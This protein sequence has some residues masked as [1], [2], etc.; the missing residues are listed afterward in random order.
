MLEKLLRRADA[1]ATA[2]RA[3]T[4]ARILAA[5]PAP[6]QA[7]ET[8]DGV[9]LRGRRLRLRFICDAALRNFWR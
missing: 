4:I 3:K 8:N 5:A 1:L 7:R 9:E 2:R 6:V